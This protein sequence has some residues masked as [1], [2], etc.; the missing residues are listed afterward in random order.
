MNAQIIRRNRGITENIFLKEVKI[1]SS[2]EKEY[3]VL[4]SSGCEYWVHIGKKQ[5]C[6]CPDFKR[7]GLKCKHIYFV[8]KKILNVDNSIVDKNDLENSEI[9]KIFNIEGSDSDNEYYSTEDNNDGIQ[10]TNIPNPM[11]LIWSLFSSCIVPKQ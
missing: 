4:G 6:S 10:I 8:L 5:T 2:T 7:R 3:L 9:K 11:N 1:I